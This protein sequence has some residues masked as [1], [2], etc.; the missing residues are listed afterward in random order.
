MGRKTKIDGEH[1]VAFVR[2][3]AALEVTVRY[4]G[5]ASPHPKLE[6]RAFWDRPDDR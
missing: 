4:R 1:G 3:A 5:T 2:L 6:G